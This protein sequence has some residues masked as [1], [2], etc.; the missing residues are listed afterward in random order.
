LQRDIIP[1]HPLH[2]ALLAG[3]WPLAAAA[4]LAD[5]A[6]NVSGEMQWSN[7]AAWLATGTALIAILPLLWVLGAAI[8]GRRGRRPVYGVLL[9]ALLVVAVL[10]VLVHTRDGAATLP[11]GLLL[12]GLLAGLAVAANIAGLARLRTGDVR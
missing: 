5:W 4:L 3:I 8:A 10:D 11:D 6:Y 1:I 12:S 7:F 9:V 2:A